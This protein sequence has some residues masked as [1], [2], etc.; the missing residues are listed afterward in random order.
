[1]HITLVAVGKKEPEWIR[2]GVAEYSKR[3][4]GEVSL[5]LV[6]V[7]AVKRGKTDNTES[8]LQKEA[9]KILCAIP[10]ATPYIAMD[11]RGKQLST[12]VLSE[13]LDNWIVEGLSPCFVIGG[14]DGLHASIKSG[15]METWSLSR[16]TLPHGLARVLLVE[17][18]YRAWTVLKKHP[19][20]RP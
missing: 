20:H 6:E 13:R 3:L 5:R 12:L 4:S 10:R 7:A 15:A 1:M 18:I 2:R 8:V 9:K 19:Y 14:A 11:E 16:L 17:Q